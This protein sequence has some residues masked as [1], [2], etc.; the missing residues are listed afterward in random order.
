MSRYQ[1]SSFRSGGRYSRQSDEGFLHL[2]LFY[3]LPFLLF[4]G[5]LFYCVTAKPK[6]TLEISDTKDY[7]STEATLKISSW[8][9]TKSVS[10][11]MH[12]E[13][14]D[15]GKPEKRTYTIPI[16]KNGLLEAN[17]TNLN[18]MISAQFLQVDILDDN[19]PTIEDAQIADGI[20]TVTVTD[21]QSGVDFDSI[22]AVNSE[23]VQLVPMTVDRETNT[24]SFEMDSAGLQV[25]AQD[26]AGNEVRGSF[27][28]HKEGETEM[29]E[30]TVE[31][32]SEETDAA[33]TADTA[34][35]ENEVQVT[36]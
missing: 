24:L 15:L 31:V 30:Q 7:L 18:G 22:Y 19:P 28:S 32:E 4:N 20:V 14:L 11:S 5:I 1:N 29:L 25:Y 35:A 8:F 12:G 23:G 33:D 16:Y 9:P 34:A 2:L 17:V 21:S 13:E 36:P 3:I 10:L 26:R 27:T 6:L